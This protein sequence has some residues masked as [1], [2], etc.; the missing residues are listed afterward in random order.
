MISLSKLN[1]TKY[2]KLLHPCNPHNGLLCMSLTYSNIPSH[3]SIVLPMDTF[4]LVGDMT[5]ILVKT[6]TYLL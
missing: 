4:L 1:G 5:H 2:L 3:N 6:V